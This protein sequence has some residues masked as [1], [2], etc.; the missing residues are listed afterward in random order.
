MLSPAIAALRDLLGWLFST[1]RLRE[2]LILENLALRQAVHARQRSLA[3][4]SRSIF[5]TL[6]PPLAALGVGTTR[7]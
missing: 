2:D 1:I 7:N 4:L 6:R 3:D 5:R